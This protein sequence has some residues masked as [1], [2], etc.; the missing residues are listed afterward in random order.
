[1]HK[2]PVTRRKFL[3][4]GAAAAATASIVPRRVV[5]GSGQTPPS[6]RLNIAVVG[7]GWPGCKDG[8]AL[9]ENSNIVALCDVDAAAAPGFRKKYA[10]ARQ[11]QDFRKMFDQMEKSI[12]AVIVATPDHTHAV[13]AMPAIKRGK[14]V[15]CEK[16]LA[17]SIGEVRA[18]MK[19]AAEHKVV[20]Q[21]GNQGHSSSSIRMF[22]E[23][24]WDGAI[25]NVHRIHAG[26]D[27]FNSGIDGLAEIQKPVPQPPQLDWDVWLGPAAQRAYHP[28]YHPFKWRGWTPFG[29]G[30]LGDW[31]CHVIDPV[32]WALDLG[33]PN[34]IV[35]E[36]RNYDPR[37][38]AD[39]F[40]RGERVTFTFPAKGKRGPVTLVWHSGGEKI[41]RPKELEPHRM[42]IQTGAVVYGDKGVIT[43]GSHGAGDVRIIP[44]SAMRAYKRPAPTLP[45]VP[46][47]GHEQ[48][49]AR[50]IRE[51]HKAGS[52]FSYGGPLTEIALLGV[53][54]IK[55]LGM[56]LEWDAQ[57]ARFSNCPEANA[58]VDSPPYRRG[59]SL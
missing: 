56:K 58:L 16:P 59:W 11:F 38:Q 15:Y 6:D 53:I 21:L 43:Y 7:L 57:Q 2:T 51:G 1:M 44:E 46:H 10:A 23:W 42:S 8:D 40:P 41:P 47:G 28:A 26:A 27:A 55:M 49:W 18:L 37:A 14:H 30:T 24:I 34:T 25:G 45:R 32:F 19:A 29:D 39:V 17:H 4:A 20:T 5:A 33:A 12:D 22:C 50:A 54:A 3:K 48:D 9:A 35:A 13:V 52:D 31:A 36:S